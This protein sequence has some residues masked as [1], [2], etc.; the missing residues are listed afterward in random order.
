MKI[1]VEGKIVHLAKGVDLF[2]V[3]EAVAY[4]VGKM[5]CNNSVVL[6]SGKLFS[7]IG[8]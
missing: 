5:L 1:E 6:V 7:R 4:D 8:G 3:T 2:C